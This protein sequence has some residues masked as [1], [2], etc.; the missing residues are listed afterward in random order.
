MEI[1]EILNV[2]VANKA[3]RSVAKISLHRQT[4]LRRF[5]KL[6]KTVED[7]ENRKAK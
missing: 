2:C 3:G 1:G 5:R 7:M 4:N 6:E